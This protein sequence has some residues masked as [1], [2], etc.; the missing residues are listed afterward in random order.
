MTVTDKP[1]AAVFGREIAMVA[2][3]VGNL[4]FHSLGKQASCP[5]AQNFGERIGESSWLGQL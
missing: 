5:I 4:G 1:L 3:P 2:E